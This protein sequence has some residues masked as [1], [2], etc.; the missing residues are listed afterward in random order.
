MIIGIDLGNYAVKTSEGKTFLSKLI[1]S[2]GF[3]KGIEVQMDGIRYLVGQGEF[4][5]DYNKSMKDNIIT[6]LFSALAVSNLSNRYE[7]VIG[8]P[9][10]Q[11]KKNKDSLKELIL[12]NSTK[13]LTIN[14]Q[15]KEIII[16]ALEIAPEGA[17][18]FNNLPLE[19]QQ[20]I[21]SKTLTIVDIGG[22]TTNVISI[23]NGQITKYKTIPLGMLNVYA[24]IVS[25]AN[26]KFSQNFK[27][28]FAEEIIKEGLFLY[29]EYQDIKFIKPILKI[30]FDSIY[31]ELQ[32]NFDVDKGY[33]LLTGGG[34]YIFNAPFRNRLKN[35]ITSKDAIFDN[36][37]GFKKVGEKLWLSR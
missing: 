37:K 11:H 35:I 29:G 26:E 33:V 12:K 13:A 10:Q 17:S 31:K 34:S 32:L 7:V 8:L 24:D 5:T 3:T 22:R 30:H 16:S 15:Y 14:G 18:A 20:L 1:E 25:Y 4:Q 19:T 21:G 2:N 23:K 36:A 28:E 27:L 6:L 9:I